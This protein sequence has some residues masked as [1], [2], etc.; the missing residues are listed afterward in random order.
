[1]PNFFPISPWIIGSLLSPRKRSSVLA[2]SARRACPAR[3]VATSC[4]LAPPLQ[5]DFDINPGREI[6]S[7]Q[8]PNRATAWLEHIDQPLVRPD[9]ELLLR[10]LVDER[11]ADHAELF[12]P[13]RQRD[14]P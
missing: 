10:I 5:L 11:R 13:G 4:D 7:H 9:F 12:N 2:G 6:Q 1:M 3:V 14:G 8:R